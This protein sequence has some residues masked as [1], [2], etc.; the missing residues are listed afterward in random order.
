MSLLLLLALLPSFVPA[1]PPAAGTEM[2]VRVTYYYAAPGARMF[3]GE[4]PRPGAAACSTHFAI[5]TVIRL[6]GWYEVTC[7][8][9]GHLYGEKWIDVFAAT[10][11]DGAYIAR[12]F[13]PYATGEVVSVPE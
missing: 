8:D 2:R 7:L 1:P 13:S 5:G 9:R 11:E 6:D 3:N 10:P 12:T 4:H